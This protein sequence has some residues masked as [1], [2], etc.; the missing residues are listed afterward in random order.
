M[1]MKHAIVC[2][3]HSYVNAVFCCHPFEHIF[4]L[5]HFI[6]H[7]VSWCVTCTKLFEACSTRSYHPC[8]FHLF[9]Y[10]PWLSR[11][12][13][14]FGLH[15]GQWMCRLQIIVGNCSWLMR[16][17]IEQGYVWSW[18]W[19][20]FCLAILAAALMSGLNFAILLGKPNCDLLA[21]CCSHLKLMWPKQKC[22]WSRAFCAGVMFAFFHDHSY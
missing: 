9:F 4:C 18:L 3:V 22:H 2:L 11:V 12:C 1:C 21:N 7:K 6:N 5:C 13:L 14:L 17:N 20:L 8:T 10:F 15:I 16:S 19:L